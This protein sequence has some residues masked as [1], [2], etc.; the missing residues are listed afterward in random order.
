VADS[1]SR[2]HRP[3]HYIDY[4]REAAQVDE[5]FAAFTEPLPRGTI[6]QLVNAHPTIPRTTIDG[7]YDQWQADHLW[8]PYDTNRDRSHA[9]L[10]PEG[11]SHLADEI[12]RRRANQEH[13]GSGEF[14]RMAT[15]EFIIHMNDCHLARFCASA[16]FMER[17]NRLSG[18]SMRS[19]TYKKKA[20]KEDPRVIQEFLDSIAAAERDFTA[21][22]VWNMDE[23]GWKDIQC[24]GRTIATRGEESVH[25]DVNGDP[26]AQ[27]TA[28]RT[29]SKS[30]RKLAPIYILRGETERAVA[31]FEAQIGPGRST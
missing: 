14:A 28:V 19:V 8:R 26:K 12:R 18:F 4:A 21:D 27:V 5:I 3:E 23:T 31:E 2:R 11:M 17:F 25:V 29:I 20:Y 9:A 22:R 1:Q 13:I 30:R 16:S 24:S 6:T 7:W 10:P 15:R